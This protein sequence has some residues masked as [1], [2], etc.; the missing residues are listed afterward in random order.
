M[1]SIENIGEAIIR[2]A[3]RAFYYVIGALIWLI[4]ALR[5]VNER[6]RK[7][8]D[9]KISRYLEKRSIEPRD[10]TVL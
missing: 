7:N 6:L 2:L 8:I 10:Y 9:L 1:R 3:N 5:P 4:K